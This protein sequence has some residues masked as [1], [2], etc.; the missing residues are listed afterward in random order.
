MYCV[1]DP[2]NDQRVPL[3]EFIADCPEYFEGI[4]SWRD[5]FA[6]IGR[7]FYVRDSSYD[8]KRDEAI[9]LFIGQIPN[10]SL[11]AYNCLGCTQFFFVNHHIYQP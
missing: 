9:K 4:G 8:P 10:I 3:A 5:I 7:H 11:P 1:R 2:K 6:A